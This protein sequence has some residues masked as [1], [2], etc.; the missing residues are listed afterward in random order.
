MKGL[1][2]LHS[3]NI[4]HRN[5]KPRYLK[6]FYWE[7][8]NIVNLFLFY[9]NV[10]LKNDVL[11]LADYGLGYDMNETQNRNGEML[12]YSAPEVLNKRQHFCNSDIW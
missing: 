1:F 7:R 12:N 8:V 6:L 3:N 2:F 5:L 4:I 11:K 9:S 10:M